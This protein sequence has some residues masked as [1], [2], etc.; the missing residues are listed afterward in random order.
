MSENQD[1]LFL[2]AHQSIAGGI[3]KSLIRAAQ[4]NSNTLQIFTKNSNRWA[5]K[6]IEQKDI[7]KFFQLKEELKIKKIIAHA[8]Y[9]VNLASSNNNIIEK[10]LK[11]LIEDIENCLKLN[12]KY[13]VLHPGSHK[14]EGVNKGIENIAKNLDNILK[15]FKKDNIK[16]LLE[17]TAGQGHSIG[18]KLEH[19]KNIRE[20]MSY[21]EKIGYCI[22]TCHIFAAGY[23]FRTLE[24]YNKF[25]NLLLETLG[26]SNIFA[27]HF[28]D[29][30]KELGSRVDRHEHI[31]KGFI[32]KDGFK[33]FLN[34]K[35]FHKIPFILETPKENNMDEV[36]LNTLKKLI[37]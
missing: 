32:G 14:G 21:Y 27:I 33:F 25:K 9:L 4:I 3:Y 2:G 12:I 24:K 10:S 35:D 26:I 20:N 5:G 36:N 30:K 1:K 19:L 18:H 31:G 17:T 13:L 28:N 22:D 8:P 23:D 29:S 16:I 11:S 15:H 7:E 6:K 34:D 37:L